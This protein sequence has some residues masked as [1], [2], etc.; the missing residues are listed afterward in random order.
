MIVLRQPSLNCAQ[1]QGS[2][3][4][5]HSR[6]ADLHIAKEQNTL[7]QTDYYQIITQFVRQTDSGQ[8]IFGKQRCIT[9]QSMILK[10]R[11]PP[12]EMILRKPSST[13]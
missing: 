12:Q 13:W 4:S 3:L 9:P 8:T 10:E 5:S 2:H 1:F 6:H 11:L 7:N